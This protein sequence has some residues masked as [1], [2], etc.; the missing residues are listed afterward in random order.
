VECSETPTRHVLVVVL[1]GSDTSQLAQG[2]AAAAAVE[3]YIDC[4]FVDAHPEKLKSSKQRDR[5][6]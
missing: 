2:H 1:A 6:F 4:S 3:G 5:H